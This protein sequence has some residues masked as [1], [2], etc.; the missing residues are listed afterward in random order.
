MGVGVASGEFM[1]HCIRMSY[2]TLAVVIAIIIIIPL[3]ISEVATTEH[4]GE[5]FTTEKNI[6]IY[7]CIRL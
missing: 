3:T 1:V 2:A 6:V 7:Y 4:V 5:L